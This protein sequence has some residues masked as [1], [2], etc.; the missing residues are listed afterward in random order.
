MKNFCFSNFTFFLSFS[1]I[2]WTG[3]FGSPASSINDSSY[4]YCY[5][6][7]AMKS[8]HIQFWKISSNEGRIR[9][10]LL[11]FIILCMQIKNP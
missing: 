10:V 11:C 1:E 4:E 3:M 2:T 7:V 5:L 8:G 6:I 9:L